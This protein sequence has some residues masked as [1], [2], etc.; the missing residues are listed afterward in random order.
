M[1]NVKKGHDE[2]HKF[3]ELNLALG[4]SWGLASCLNLGSNRGLASCLRFGSS[5]GLAGFHLYIVPE[6]EFALGSGRGHASCLNLG[7]NGGLASWLRFGSSG[8]LAGYHRHIVP[9]LEF[10]LGSCGSL[11]L[12]S[13]RFGEFWRNGK[14]NSDGNNYKKRC[15]LLSLKKDK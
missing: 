6:L 15:N 10:A 11:G 13:R 12:R 3:L 9:E 14:D 8:G 5:G 1:M 2:G 4:N 7:S